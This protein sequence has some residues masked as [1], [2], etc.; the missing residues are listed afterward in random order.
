MWHTFTTPEGFWAWVGER[1]GPKRKIYLFAHNLMFD[2]TIVH[3]F[4]LLPALGWQLKRAVVEDPPT[5]LT[6]RKGTSTIC[7]LDTFNWFHT[8]L[9]VLGDS[10]GLAKLTMPEQSAPQADW[11]AYCRRDVEVLQRAMM[12]YLDFI[13]LNDLGN[14]QTTAASQALTAYRH[15][16]LHHPVYI[17]VNEPALELARQAYYG[18]RTEA[19]FVGKREGDY[20]LLDVNS[21]YPF[22]MSIN[23]FPAKL[24]G[25]YT[26][27][28]EASMPE[29]LTRAQVIADVSLD[30][31]EPAFPM[32]TRGPL[33]F[34]TGQF[35]T[36]LCTPE[37]QYALDMG[38]V[39]KIHQAAIYEH[40][41]LF[42][43]YVSTIFALRQKYQAEGNLPFS[44]LS[45]LLLNSL[46]GKFGQRG[47]IYQDAGEALTDEVRS[48]IEY[49]GDS[50]Q[51]TQHR[52]FGGLHQVWE[53]EG[54]S[55]NSHP[56]IAAHVTSYAR[57]WLW[58]L[59][60][61]A[62][63]EHVFYCDTDSLVV[64]RAGYDA[65]AP[66][67]LGDGLGE[68]KLERQFCHLVIHGCKDYEF[69]DVTKIKG[70]RKN[71]VATGDNQY[72]QEAFRK[73][74]GMV[75]SG[76]LDTMVVS[77]QTK[78][79]KRVYQKGYVDAA[80]WVRPFELPAD[81]DC[82]LPAKYVPHGGGAGGSR[83]DNRFVDAAKRETMR[84]LLARGK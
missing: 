41:P 46:Y 52:Q 21:M 37:L 53:N 11:D 36:S 79:L 44:S 5:I 72:Q 61:K 75:R 38:Y 67:Y 1:C 51:I 20:W 76:D 22:V 31:P 69:G 77:T 35:R 10:M 66:F 16:F 14:F 13:K 27:I 6:Y 73:F 68:L 55:Y 40:A 19:F 33:I 3:G 74:A 50:K 28:D 30:T 26:R 9:A 54:E 82:I 83:R 63:R 32:R 12:S 24:Q 42:A 59:I 8:S 64:D 71:A 57:M 81:L 45:K 65:L 15:R 84:E 70:V 17:D 47:R 80:G 60:C 62:G 4:T 78:N 23:N 48:W 43:D 18:G 58:Q 49:S 29:L 56:A 39:R 7:L 25:V 34:P 2:F